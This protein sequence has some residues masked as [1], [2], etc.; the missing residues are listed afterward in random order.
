MAANKWYMM[1][2]ELAY[3]PIIYS[4]PYQNIQLTWWL[5]Y[6]DIAEIKM[7][8]KSV[9]DIIGTIG[10]AGATG[11]NPFNAS[12]L[13][14]IA[15]K[16]ILTQVG[17]NAVEGLQDKSLPEGNALHLGCNWLNSVGYEFGLMNSAP[18][19]LNKEIFLWKDVIASPSWS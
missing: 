6:L 11:T 15:S 7:N 5:N 3:D 2:Y 18:Q 8:S 1:Q 13:N 10:T 14:Q 12:N 4:I 19:N 17:K 9:G 16:I